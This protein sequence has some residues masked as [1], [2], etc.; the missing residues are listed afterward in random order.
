METSIAV[1]MRAEPELIFELA[2]RVEDWP[3]L[4]P[5]YR[6]VRVLRTDGRRRLVDMAARRGLIPVRWTAV[7]EFFPAE[8]RIA[9]RH[10]RG[11]TRGM[12]V[13]WTLRSVDPPGTTLV[14][15]WHGFD[16]RWPLVPDRLIELVVGQFFVNGIASRTLRRLRVI[17]EADVAGASAA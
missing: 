16:P 6:R 2:A 1:T 12:A 11:V 8:R 14:H 5:H 17:A 4:L 3:R 13:A 7:Q 10:V 15:I 9:Y